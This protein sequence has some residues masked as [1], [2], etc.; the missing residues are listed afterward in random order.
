MPL[1]KNESK[2]L[3]LL[4]YVERQAETVVDTVVVHS[5]FDPSVSGAERFSPDRCSALLTQHSVSTH[6]LIDDS[7]SVY[8]CV[9]EDKRARHAGE[10]CLPFH[11]DNRADVGEFS[12][13]IEL[14][15]DWLDD[16]F[17]YPKAQYLSLAS[18]ISDIKTRFPIRYVLGHDQIAPHRKKD[19]GS[20]F[21]WRY[22]RQL[23]KSL[24]DLTVGI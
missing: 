13:G 11:F 1:P 22:L 2:S 20:H 23:L 4:H 6:Y 19:P 5:M 15:G 16:S 7:G 17:I 9:A 14:L 12:I 18:L 8:S 24:P 3:P 21:R 10:S